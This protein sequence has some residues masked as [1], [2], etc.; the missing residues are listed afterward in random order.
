[1]NENPQTKRFANQSPSKHPEFLNLPSN[2]P[3]KPKITS[4]ITEDAKP[5]DAMELALKMESIPS[6]LHIKAKGT[7]TKVKSLKPNPNK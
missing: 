2:K 3:N 1:M 6:M 4:K 5:H 7:E